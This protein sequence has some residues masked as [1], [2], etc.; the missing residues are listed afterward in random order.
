MIIKKEELEIH[1]PTIPFLQLK[2][3]QILQNLLKNLSTETKHS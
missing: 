3:S 1:H 2:N